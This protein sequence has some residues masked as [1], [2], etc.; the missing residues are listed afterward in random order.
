MNTFYIKAFA[1]NQING[2]Q[3]L[4]LRPYELEELGIMSIGHQEV[5]LEAVEHLRNFVRFFL[6]ALDRK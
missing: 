6:S 4:S 5:I 2:N 1:N 3:L